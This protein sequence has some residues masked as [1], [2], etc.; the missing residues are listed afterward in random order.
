MKW[1]FGH[2][3][4]E[5]SASESG[6]SPGNVLTDFG[7]DSSLFFSWFGSSLST[8]VYLLLICGRR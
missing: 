8:G 6:V 5:S 3:S 4:L 1:D 7:S 2:A